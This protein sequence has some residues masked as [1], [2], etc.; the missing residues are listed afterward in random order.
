MKTHMGEQVGGTLGI[1]RTKA[2]ERGE[3]KSS[4]RT[5]LTNFT[6]SPEGDGINS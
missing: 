6:N 3:A 4:L 1:L 5:K 2:Q